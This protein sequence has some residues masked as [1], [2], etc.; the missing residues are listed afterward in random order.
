MI[1]FDLNRETCLRPDW[2]K[3]GIG[4]FLSQK[5]CNCPQPDPGCYVDGWKIT[6]AGSRFLRPEETRYAPVE[7][8]AL[9][10]AY[11]LEQ[12]RYFTQGCDQLL[13][14]TDHKPLTKLFGDRT[15]DEITNPRL[16]GLKQQTLLWRFSIMHKPGKD[17]NFSDATS[18]NPSINDS[19]VE[20][21]FLQK[22]CTYDKDFDTMEIELASLASEG[23]FIVTWETV[24]TESQKDPQIRDLINIIASGFPLSKESLP[25]TLQD[26]WK[27]RN[28][29]YV[30][31]EVV[32]Y[33]NRI[34]IP[35]SLRKD[36]LQSL[37]SAHQGVS[38][39]NERAKV[40]IYWPNITNDIQNVRDS[41]RDCNRIAQTQPKLP[42]QDPFVPSTPFEA[43]ACDYFF[44][45]GWY[46][47]IAADRLSCWTEISKIRQGTTESGSTG[48][49]TAFRKL[50]STFGVPY[51]VSSDA[52][53][54]FKAHNTEAFF[55]RW[56]IHHRVSSSYLPSSN[57]RAEVAV[58]S[59]KRLLM[60]NISADGNLDTDEM[61][62][63]LLMLR[64]TPDP[65]CRLS[66]AEVIFGRR[67]PDSLPGISKETST[68][69]NPHIAG[70]WKEA[71]A[72]KEQSLKERY[73]KSTE[74]LNH[75]SHPLEPLNVGN[76]VFIQNQTG[77][78]P[79]RWDRS[80]IIMEVL[81][82]D[83][84]IVKV[85][86]SGRLTTRN[87]RYL[88]KFEPHLSYD[89]HTQRQQPILPTTSSKT[90]TSSHV[91]RPTVVNVQE[92]TPSPQPLLQDDQREDPPND[93]PQSSSTSTQEVAS[94]RIER[95]S[96]N[97]PL[98]RSGRDRR[99]TK[100]YEP[101]SGK[102]VDR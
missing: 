59:A 2:S 38:A 93:S 84:Y 26:F 91:T 57:G 25:P 72:L 15:L 30:I 78:N 87:R 9:A 74:A 16:R 45:M 49:C 101:E 61:V 102:Y 56:G 19:S 13:V 10:I 85:S 5:H 40:E 53:P 63:A 75:R 32:L 79:T 66:P 55:N 71:W 28:D 36:V 97:V 86:G 81:D 50:F 27:Y 65:N 69:D 67:L 44:F 42:P 7:G 48:L 20:N 41:C 22:I 54:E 31:D 43:I 11:S 100:V 95:D 90:P 47:L 23:L 77:I 76:H 60:K 83:K 52:G 34:V 68:Y 70:R 21:D 88:R 14:V 37:H 98:R 39:M 82:F 89:T 29:L 6:L 51:E 80:G 24:K 8:E 46:Y 99:P 12:T 35:Q 73:V 96:R 62:R 33:K 94:P 92:A 3:T 18:R 4:F 64:N 1:I 17:N 58:K